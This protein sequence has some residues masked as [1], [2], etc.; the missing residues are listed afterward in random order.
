MGP[1]KIPLLTGAFCALSCWLPPGVA[2][3][4]PKERL[5]Y[6]REYPAIRYSSTAPTDR[7]ADLERKIESGDVRL[8]FDP[9][10]GYLASLL[11]ALGL[12]VA[13][14]ILVFTKTS[15]QKGRISPRSPRAIYFTDDAYLAW[16]QGGSSIEISAVD[17]KLGAVFYTLAQEEAKPPRFERQTFVCLQCHDSYSLTGGGVP[18][19]I[20]GS[21]IPDATGRLASHEGW[22]LTTDETPIEKRWGGWYV[23]GASG[24]ERHMGNVFVRD[25]SEL[26]AL[27]F[28]KTADVTDLGKLFDTKPYLGRGSDIVALLVI[29]HQVHVQNLITRVHWDTLEALSRDDDERRVEAI[30]EPLVQAMTFAHEAE[31]KGPIS[32]TS[33]FA[34][35]F[36]AR[37]PRD[38]RGRS[39]R[40]FDL[41]TRLF[42]YPLSYLIYSEAFEALP[43]KTRSY[44]L[45]RIREVLGDRK[46]GSDAGRAALEILD[47]TRPEPA[48][49]RGGRG[50]EASHPQMPSA[51][52]R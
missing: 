46:S 18:R 48:A 49:V 15:F 7:V 31:L 17:P 25:G 13:S 23:T 27:D 35:E 12:P 50:R 19:H 11:R 44:V 30:A 10:T 24:N 6:D 41:E 8:S 3:Q 45:R 14:Q 26:A 34:E 22:S 28:S 32:G 20:M 21:G 4:P 39:L 5:R 9:A 1:L 43:M 47:A 42:R 38:A 37:G 16:V 29:E 2:A 40:E 51:R 36:A 33:G 52:S